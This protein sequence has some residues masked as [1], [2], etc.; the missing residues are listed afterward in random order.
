MKE[1]QP[2]CQAV[3]TYACPLDSHC[4]AKPFPAKRS[5]T[6]N[7][8]MTFRAIIWCETSL[9]RAFP[10]PLFPKLS[11]SK[12]ARGRSSRALQTSFQSLFLSFLF[13]RRK[14]FQTSGHYFS[15]TI[16]FLASWPLRHNSVSVG[17]GWEEASSCSSH[18]H[19]P[20]YGDSFSTAIHSVGHRQ[21]VDK[22]VINLKVNKNLTTGNKLIFFISTRKLKYISVKCSES[23][24]F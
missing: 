1:N 20:L 7:S 17:G 5:L 6:A 8:M 21:N 23:H 14:Y 22:R 11:L 24:Q 19:H 13:P 2:E 9:I 3:Y 16:V 12:T 4:R 10:S 15:C 18:I